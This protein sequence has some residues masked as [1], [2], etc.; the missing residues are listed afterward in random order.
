[1]K[2]NRNCCGIGTVSA[3]VCDKFLT[4]ELKEDKMKTNAISIFIAVFFL[5]FLTG[6][7]TIF[8]GYED[9]VRIK[10]APE[11]LQVFTK[12]SIEIPVITKE[13]SVKS[14]REAVY[15]PIKVKEISLRS[16]TDHVLV[17]KHQG[18][19]KRIHIYPHIET[20]W[21]ILGCLTLTGWVDAYTGNWNYFNEI[22]ANY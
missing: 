16:N 20:G 8:K 1:L 19:E 9:S 10:N 18:K 2:N 7:A 4:T 14:D 15:Y 11:G 5:T 17:L 22:D 6:C 21:F 13:I 3:V 12:D